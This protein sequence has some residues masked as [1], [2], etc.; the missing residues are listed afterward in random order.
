VSRGGRSSSGAPVQAALRRLALAAGAAAAL[1]GC[2]TSALPQEE[3]P[4]VAIA[5]VHRSIEDAERLQEMRE[6]TEKARRPQLNPQANRSVFDLNQAAELV[7]LSD[8]EEARA[9]ARLGRIAFYHPRRGE[10]EVLEWAPRGTRPLAWSPDRKRLLYLM[11]QRGATQVFEYDLAKDRLTSVTQVRRPHLHAAYGPEGQVVFSRWTPVVGDEGGIRLF[12]RDASGR[13]QPITPGPADTKPAVGP[14]TRYVV[15]ERRDLEGRVMI[16]RVDLDE[17]V[18]PEGEVRILAT[19]TDPSIT[20]DGSWVVY[21]ARLG[22]L[23][24]IWRMRPDGSGKQ[25]VGPGLVDEDELDPSVSP[26]GR[27][28]VFVSRE[29]EFKR[30]MVRPL[31]GG[32]TWPLITEGEGLEPIW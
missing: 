21:A 29:Y 27:F 30:L 17:A 2:A 5:F 32:P 25:R 7:G 23:M 3:L 14:G 11:Y 10:I 9:A 26:D 18:R 1:G 22:G 8:G 24:R 12:L 20:P 13:A 16:A 6:R 19:G 4:E 31:D 15:F 28:V